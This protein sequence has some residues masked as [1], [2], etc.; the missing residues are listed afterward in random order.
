[1]GTQRVNRAG[2]LDAGPQLNLTHSARRFANIKCFSNSSIFPLAGTGPWALI[3]VYHCRTSPEGKVLTG[4]RSM[5]RN[6]PPQQFALGFQAWRSGSSPEADGQGS[7]SSRW[8]GRKG[9][10]GQACWT[11]EA[12]GVLGTMP[13]RQ[14][15]FA[16]GGEGGSGL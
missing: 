2:S 11:C 3:N 15:V 8:F 12:H 10:P 7:T 5:V 4:P 9:A 14:A 16:V 13:K 6:L 1:M